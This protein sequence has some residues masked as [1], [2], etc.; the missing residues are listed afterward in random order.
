MPEEFQCRLQDTAGPIP[1][2]EEVRGKACQPGALL[3]RLPIAEQCGLAASWSSPKEGLPLHCFSHHRHPFSIPRQHGSL[4]V[5]PGC[6]RVVGAG[7]FGSDRKGNSS[8]WKADCCPAPAPPREKRKSRV[9]A[10]QSVPAT[11]TSLLTTGSRCSPGTARL[12]NSAERSCLCDGAQPQYALLWGSVKLGWAV[13][14][15]W[16]QHE[17]VSG[18]ARPFLHQGAARHRGCSQGPGCGEGTEPRALGKGR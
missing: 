11:G 16:P 14:A 4:P 7:P 6:S 15:A 1:L 5:W 3:T 2:L 9:S 18:P 8:L 13:S 17:W 12:S 10:L